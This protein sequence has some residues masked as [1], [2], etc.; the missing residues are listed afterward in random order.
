MVWLWLGL[1][2][3]FMLGLISAVLVYWDVTKHGGKSLVWPL[4]CIIF[5]VVGLFVYYFFVRP[6][7][8][9]GR[10]LPK[11]GDYGKPDYGFP[12]PAK[13]ENVSTP[14]APEVTAAMEEKVESVA[15]PFKEVVT[16]KVESVKKEV[17]PLAPPPLPEAKTAEPPAPAKPVV[18]QIEGIPRC[19]ECG[20]AISSYDRK[21]PACGHALR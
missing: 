7:P 6:N 4:H 17:E 3:W 21:C 9:P 10:E 15:E 2:I 13:T 1:W 16:E 20:A 19:P 11:P 8:I 18:K 12:E 5:S 14:A